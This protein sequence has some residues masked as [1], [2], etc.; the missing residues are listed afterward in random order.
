MTNA[1]SLFSLPWVELAPGIR[2]KRAVLASQ[3]VRLLEHASAHGEDEFC[4]KAHSGVV[5]EGAATLEFR[6]G[7]KVE[8][9]QGDALVLRAGTED[10]H[11]VTVKEG[12]SV[13]FLL[14]EP[15]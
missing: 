9:S 3:V 2:E 8:L 12:G 15:A 7:E 1:L 4:E 6:R 10:A 11:R 5:L 14:V 13:L